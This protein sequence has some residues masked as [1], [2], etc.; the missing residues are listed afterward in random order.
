MRPEFFKDAFYNCFLLYFVCCTGVFG[1][2]FALKIY[3]YKRIKESVPA[4]RLDFCYGFFEDSFPLGIITG[5]IKVSAQPLQSIIAQHFEHL[6][7]DKVDV[8]HGG[9]PLCSHIVQHA[10]LA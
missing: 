6:I 8:G 1:T 3:V 2:K 9:F 5:D 7:C 4:N 10:D